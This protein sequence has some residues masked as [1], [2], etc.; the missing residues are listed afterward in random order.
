MSGRTSTS[1]KPSRNFL[2][3]DK[4]LGKNKQNRNIVLQRKVWGAFKTLNIIKKLV[5]FS[6]KKKQ[7]TPPS[8]PP[9]CQILLPRRLWPYIWPSAS[10]G[11][12]GTA[13]AGS[14]LKNTQIAEKTW[15]N[16]INDIFLWKQHECWK[17][18]KLK[19]KT[20][21]AQNQTSNH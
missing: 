16:W 21:R 3:S 9:F 5:L 17:K 10:C 4:T 8:A 7:L 12:A 11:S 20:N 19:G 13:A 1:W 2:M 14:D 6:Q 15:R 18:L